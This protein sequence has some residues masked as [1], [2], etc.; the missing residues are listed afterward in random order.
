MEVLAA[1]PQQEGAARVFPEDLT[2]TRLYAFWA[3]VRE[4]AGL[5]GVRLHDAR[6][7][8]ASQGV[9][10]GVGLTAV[11]KLLGHREHTTTAIY[12]H[13]DDAALR[14]AGQT[15][16][17][18][19]RAIGYQAAPPTLCRDTEDWTAPTAR[20]EFLRLGEQEVPRG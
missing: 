13:L 18:I 7:T 14:D 17:V 2:T 10:N 4:E 19:A 6:H 16:T 11:G 5:H 3:G 12:A 8:Y 15:A 20:P 9:M 1:L